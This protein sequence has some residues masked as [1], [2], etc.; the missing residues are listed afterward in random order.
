MSFELT[1]SKYI[2][3]LRR[4]KALEE[5]VNNL[6]VAL[7]KC[8]TQQQLSEL[9]VLV[10]SDIKDCQEQLIALDNRITEIEEEPLN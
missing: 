4:V 8:T 3:L 1:E 5:M 6:V 7:D 9:L 10:Q 2:A